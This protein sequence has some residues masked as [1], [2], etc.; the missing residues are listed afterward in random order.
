MQRNLHTRQKWYAKLFSNNL[1]AS[2]AQAASMKETLNKL[3]S[4]NFVLM[5]LK[6]QGRQKCCTK[7]LSNKV[8][9]YA[10]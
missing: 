9:P 6:L 2:T 3:L 5:Y 10:A 4:N 8:S 7:F 1:N